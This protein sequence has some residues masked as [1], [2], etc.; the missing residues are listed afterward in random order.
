MRNVVVNN[1]H[2]MQKSQNVATDSGLMSTSP[3][4]VIGQNKPSSVGI[5]AQSMFGSSITSNSVPDHITS[6]KPKPQTSVMGMKTSYTSSNV[7]LPA[8]GSNH[9]VKIYLCKFFYLIY[10]VFN[11]NL[12]FF[13]ILGQ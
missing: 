3:G 10:Y 13:E 1:I 2:N 12:L 6:P 9:M 4:R 8:H 5:G 7:Y 11:F